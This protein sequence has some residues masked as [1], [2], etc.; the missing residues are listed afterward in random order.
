MR[1]ENLVTNRTV[2]TCGKTCFGTGRGT[3]YVTDSPCVICAKL[4]INA[5]ISKIVYKGEYPDELSKKLLS[6]AGV[7]VVQYKQ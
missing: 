4:A 2:L 5:G 6:E 3:L 1:Y 7:E